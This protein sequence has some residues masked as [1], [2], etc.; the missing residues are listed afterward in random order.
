M[1]R[2]KVHRDR[3]LGRRRVPVS[4]EYTSL[5]NVAY[6]SS[7]QWLMKNEVYVGSL[8]YCGVLKS[9]TGV[10]FELSNQSKVLLTLNPQQA[11]EDDDY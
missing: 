6:F 9:W 8:I 3:R 2:L 4:G 5:L 11:V 7:D 1:K 10:C